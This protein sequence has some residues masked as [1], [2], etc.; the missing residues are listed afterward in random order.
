MPDFTKRV[1]KAAAASL[2]PGESIHKSLAGQPPGSLTRGMN[3][4][5]NV[6]YGIIR[7]R[8]EKA[9]HAEEAVG[10]GAAIPPRNVYL[11]LTDRRMLVHTMSKV[12]KVE[13]LVAEY[14]YRQITDVRFE[15]TRLDGGVL[16]LTFRDETGVDFLITQ[17]QK[18][19]VFVAVWEDHRA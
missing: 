14:D 3:E 5:F 19:E 2:A 16:E 1:A 9:R 13:D 4:R 6:E 17:R 15:K 11:T 7:G 10:L 18:P 8:K 12:G